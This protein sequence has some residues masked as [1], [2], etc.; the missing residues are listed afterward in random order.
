ME[1]FKKKNTALQH[2]LWK[3]Q[4]QDCKESGLSI[5]DWCRENDIHI[6]TY[7]YRLRAIDRESK[8]ILQPIVPL[9]ISK[10]IP[11]KETG[12]SPVS[13]SEIIIHRGI[14]EVKIPY[15]A[16]E[17]ILLTILRGLREC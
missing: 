15:N 13:T 2:K 11:Q 6:Q 3:K 9:S 17:Q 5:K 4:I 16:P 14:I 8:D 12:S 7:Y 1:T 10:N